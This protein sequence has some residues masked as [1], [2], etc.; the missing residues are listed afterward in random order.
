MIVCL[1]SQAKHFEE[2]LLTIKYAMK[3]LKIKPREA[4]RRDRYW[5]DLKKKKACSENSKFSE[6]YSYNQGCLPVNVSDISVDLEKDRALL[7]NLFSLG[8]QKAS[9]DH[10]I[11]AITEEL[12]GLDKELSALQQRESTDSN[13]EDNQQNAVFEKMK[14]VA[15]RMEELMKSREIFLNQIKEIENKKRATSN[16]ILAKLETLSQS[17]LAFKSS[18]SAPTKYKE[19]TREELNEDSF[20]SISDLR[21]LKKEIEIL[22][23]ELMT[24]DS[25]IREYV[26]AFKNIGYSPQRPKLQEP[27]SK[28]FSIHAPL[29]RNSPSKERESKP[30]SQVD[31]NP[32]A[33]NF[34]RKEK[35]DS[36]SPDLA[37]KGK[38]S[39]IITKLTE[40]LRPASSSEKGAEILSCLERRKDSVDQAI[41]E[42]QKSIKKLSYKK[43]SR[44]GSFDNSIQKK[45]N[46]LRAGITELPKENNIAEKNSPASPAEDPF[47]G[48][49][50]VAAKRLSEQLDKDPKKEDEEE[51][52]KSEAHSRGLFHPGAHT[53]SVRGYDGLAPSGPEDKD[54]C[55]NP[56]SLYSDR[57]PFSEI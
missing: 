30:Q 53:L 47:F 42:V 57:G 13:S 51:R 52:E 41:K 19:T 48:I 31:L 49:K 3:A 24:K 54:S 55:T 7:A 12:F 34:S 44:S 6:E 33:I 5:Q 29:R 38:V 36:G 8:E 27:A 16:Q 2:T 1:S 22:R 26:Y 40:E 28:V 46:F 20:S 9:K 50:I 15:D 11:N 43:V 35:K 25:Q 17:L 32:M 23:K 56:M 10:Q 21:H 45:N 39:E 4:V 37:Q 14:Q 18:K